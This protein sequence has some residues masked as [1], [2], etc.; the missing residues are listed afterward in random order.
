M[1]VTVCPMAVGIVMLGNRYPPSQRYTGWARGLFLP[2]FLSSNRIFHFNRCPQ[3]TETRLITH[4]LAF[5]NIFSPKAWIRITLWTWHYILDCSPRHKQ[6]LNLISQCPWHP[7]SW[8][9]SQH[10]RAAGTCVLYTFTEI[11]HQL[12]QSEE[13]AGRL[14]SLW[15]VLEF[16]TIH[17]RLQLGLRHHSSLSF[18]KKPVTSQGQGWRLLWMSQ[19]LADSWVS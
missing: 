5:M 6:H 4:L 13:D 19:T 12:S 10:S 15:K 1:R 11:P 7:G 8:I 14:R 9:D 2:P 3:S 18:P 17:G 16:I